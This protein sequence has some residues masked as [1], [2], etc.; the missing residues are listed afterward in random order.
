MEEIK[1]Q[2]LNMQREVLNALETDL[3]KSRSAVSGDVGDEIDVA[4]EDTFKDY[5]NLMSERNQQKLELIR[6]ALQA[7][8]NNTYGI[9]DEC[10]GKINKKRLKALPFTK[11]C[12]EC[13]NELERT[14]LF[15][16]SLSQGQ[17][18]VADEIDI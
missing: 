10:G 4:I 9:C 13:K 2:L 7:I 8:E 1:Q 5:Y 18:L 17:D 12:I 3:E 16:R 11:Y 6:Q 14:R 15:E